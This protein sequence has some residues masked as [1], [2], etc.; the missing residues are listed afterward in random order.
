[1]L[2]LK[3]IQIQGFKSFADKM[4]MTFEGSG[5]IGIVGPNGCGK[6]NVSDAIAW[7]LGEQSAKSLRGGRMEDVIFNGTR[8]RLP[9]GMAEVSLTLIDP[10]VQK[11][12]N[13]AFTPELEPV[14]AARGDGIIDVDP[15]E[16]DE[17]AAQQRV[18]TIEAPGGVSTPGTSTAATAKR[19]RRPKFQPK[20]GELVVSRRLF[21]SGES[22]YLLNG[23]QVRLRDIQDIFLGTGLGPDSYA[24]IEQGRV[25][26]ILSSKPSDRRSIIE[27]AAGI[28]KFKS[29]RK[30]AESKLE[31]AKQN[32][33]R[34]NDITEEVS[35]Q[36][37]SLKRQAAKAKRY[38]ELRESMRELAKNLFN[39]R[40]VILDDQCSRN[41][42]Q[43]EEVTEC[44]RQR[45]QHIDE[46]E[47]S[48]RET[49]ASIFDLENRLKELR[50][51]LSQ[52]NLAADRGQQRIE[53]QKEQ[54]KELDSRTQENVREIEKL[55]QQEAQYQSEADLKKQSLAAATEQFDRIE[56]DFASQNSSYQA[57]QSQVEEL[58][59]SN[60]RHRVGLLE[61]VSQAAT[62]HNQLRQLDD[63][64][65]RLENQLKRL[66]QER[67][68]S[69]LFRLRLAEE[70]EVSERQQ[71]EQER[72][73]AMLKEETATL[74][75]ALSQLKGEAA[76][77][78]DVLTETKDQF[79]AATH[80]VQSLE[81]L[82]AHR[83][84][85]TEA[86]RILLAAAGEGMQES[87]ATPGILADL[88][89][90]E[91]PY[92]AMVE[93]FLK[94][95]LEF[96][97]VETP[98]TARTGMALLNKNNAGRSTFLVFGD[99]QVPR[100]NGS[101]DA[102]QV[103]LQCDPSLIP[104]GNVIRIAA[105]YAAVVEEAL[106][107]LTCS[108]I[109]SSY[110]QAVRLGEQFPQ[111]IFLSAGGEVVRGRLISG[112][113]KASLGHLTLRREIRDLHR[114]V[115]SLEKGILA[116]HE[117]QEVLVQSI[118][119]QEHTLAGVRQNAQELEK[120]LFAADLR[121][122]QIQNEL[123]RIDQRHK[124]AVLES[125]RTEAEM[126][127]VLS[128][129]LQHQHDI[130]T[131]ENHKLE[132]EGLIASQSDNLKQLKDQSSREAQNLSELRSE[133]A[134]FRERKL[135]AES[136]LARLGSSMEECQ[137]RRER[138]EAQKT[139]WIAQTGEIHAS[140]RQLEE[141]LFHQ[142]VQKASLEAEIRSR[143]SDLFEVRALQTRLEQELQ[144][145]RGE[146]EAI[147]IE[148]TQLEIERAK[149]GSDLSHLQETCLDELGLNLEDIRPETV[150]VLEEGEL[151]R[152]T[153]E[154]QELKERIEAMGPVNMMALEEYQ[155]CEQRFQFLSTQRQ[156]LLDSI[157]DTTAAIKEID[158]VSREQFREAFTAI[159]ANFQ[160]SFQTLF[161]GGHGEMKLLDEN[162]ELDSGIE[163][164]AQPPG[165]RLQNVLLLSGG[166]KAL[167]AI[168][169]LLA[170]FKFQPSPFCVLDEVDAPLD[171]V[172]T[173]RYVHMIKAMSQGTQFLLITHSQRT[174]EIADT[175]YGVTM[176]EAGVSKI[177]SVQFQ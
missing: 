74:A 171:D 167:T 103:A 150:L 97:L 168:A 105:D 63:L 44:S 43:L 50:Y 82:A 19:Q 113:G 95:E 41:T 21:R 169:L 20:P 128:R 61:Y 114:K 146:L 81:E 14:E 46:Q 59:T 147:Q 16:T 99:G 12:A 135:A 71:E 47:R 100:S 65:L 87:F 156:D 158:Q 10:E 34:V 31:Q 83:A 131:A 38:R 4:E 7:V 52:L 1:L 37:G 124:L 145:L 177:V 152:L 133:L 98:S 56:Q 154:Y 79:S 29:K 78:R 57:I 68:E 11:E 32:L 88:F 67:D 115:E 96:L 142:A 51:Q 166:E 108:F 132:I 60:E 143:E 159:N 129:R 104:L 101:S 18:E 91:G 176:Q 48:Y 126:A 24:I 170:I 15:F 163:I 118:D 157:E 92:E 8:S 130:A 53:F 102:A 111:F 120:N 116:Q 77:H 106:P 22:E 70:R 139:A 23:K 76:A 93:E 151:F 28:T 45:R 73:L 26:M 127:Q 136:E 110:D 5:V 94:Q 90:V 58:E 149:L 49:N 13:L 9:I 173:G 174:M 175:L 66:H 140:I 121:V 172:N 155:E 17:P 39:A 42:Q 117:K 25:G 6:S 109:A 165:K 119:S 125:E 122:K 35:K 123:E 27:E 69:A 2:K 84:H 62:L 30:L 112:G 54:L 40:A 107:Q 160:E 85:T 55:V 138:L 36:L 80:R 134:T 161:G 144:A 72:Q 75:A 64:E 3:R 86:V 137:E 148:R 162:D 33:L 153:K 164:I 89:E 141:A